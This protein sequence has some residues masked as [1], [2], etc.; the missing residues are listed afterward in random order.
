[1]EEEKALADR[2]RVEQ[3]W[4][5][6]THGL[7]QFDPEYGPGDYC[8]VPIGFGGDVCDEPIIG[9][10]TFIP[11]EEYARVREVLERLVEAVDTAED[12]GLIRSGEPDSPVQRW[13]V[14]FLGV[15]DE[16]RA[17]LRRSERAALQPTEEGEQ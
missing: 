9:P 3:L 5:C 8:P 16:A 6:P 7:F 11:S 14:E 15:T 13:R 2:S 4:R 12:S 17:A 10:A 1:M